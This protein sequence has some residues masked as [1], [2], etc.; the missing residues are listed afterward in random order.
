[1]SLLTV[2]PQ[3]PFESHC[4]IQLSLSSCVWVLIRSGQ[5]KITPPG[6]ALGKWHG[7]GKYVSVVRGYHQ[8]QGRDQWNH[9]VDREEIGD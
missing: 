7:K 1:M 2:I 4:R 8:R 3:G 9:Q 6:Q 5:F